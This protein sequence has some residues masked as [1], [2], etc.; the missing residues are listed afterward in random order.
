MFFTIE[1]P[2]VVP[3]DC[4]SSN[5]FVPSVAEKNTFKLKAVSEFGL[6]LQGKL[7]LAGYPSEVPD[8]AHVP[9]RMSAT[10]EQE[11]GTS[12]GD[13]VGE[14][15]AVDVVLGVLVGVGEPLAVEVVLGVPVMLGVVLGVADGVGEALAVEVELGVAVTLGVVLG[16]GESEDVVDGVGES[17]DVVDGVG[18]SEAVEVVLG[19]ALSDEVVDGVIEGVG[20]EL[21]EGVVEGVELS[22]GVL[23]ALGVTVL[24]REGAAV[25]VAAAATSCG[26]KSC[27]A[28][29]LL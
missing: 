11:N 6:L 9:G 7:V 1:V 24:E 19:V 17:E 3:S 4:Q 27:H 28:G 15:L 10:I 13:G 14:R 16:V 18:E 5:P 12:D 2:P 26:T 21:S 20:V 22:E 8:D 29:A 23:E 25:A